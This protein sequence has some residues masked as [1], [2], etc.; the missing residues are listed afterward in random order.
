MPVDRKGPE[1]SLRPSG[2]ERLVAKIDILMSTRP[3]RFGD[4]PARIPYPRWAGFR[5]G[6]WRSGS[7]V[8]SGCGSPVRCATAVATSEIVAVV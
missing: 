3:G 1:R 6:P 2:R 5:E 4:D 8:A 7:S